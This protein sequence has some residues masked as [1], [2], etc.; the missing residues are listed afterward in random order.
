MWGYPSDLPTDEN[1]FAP[2][3]TELGPPTGQFD[4]ID[5]HVPTSV[6]GK[7]IES[8]RLLGS[9]LLLFG[10]LVLTVWLPGN[11]LINLI[12]FDNPEREAATFRLN[13]MIEGFFSPIYVGAILHA[14]AEMQRGR[15]VGYS[16]AISVGLRGWGRLF[17]ARFFTGFFILLG[18]VALIVP[19]IILMVQYAL[20]DPIVVLE[21]RSG[22]EARS[23]SKGLTQGRRWQ[24][25]VAGI[26]FYG[27]FLP[28]TIGLYA[29]LG[30][31]EL[32]TNVATAVA[33]D[34]I[35]NL[36]SAVITILMF[37]FYW[38][39]ILS[40]KAGSTEELIG[41]ASS[42]PRWLTPEDQR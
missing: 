4:D 29:I 20:L 16:E 13:Q 14:L 22:P 10:L 17:G 27:T 1:P 28:F 40:E 5:G 2:P 11:I 34:C 9:N 25:L 23:R 26:L 35:M 21:G 19:G 8:Y 32:I 36:I 42:S 24:I 3:R 37:L 15:T 39:A 31:M 6:F 12:L 38:E 18:L 41:G 30:G 33:L 7:F